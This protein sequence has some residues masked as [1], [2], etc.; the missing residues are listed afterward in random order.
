[1]Q[2][3]PPLAFKRADDHDLAA[4]AQFNREVTGTELSAAYWRWKY[5]DNPRQ[6]S[7]VVLALDADRIVGFMA[8]FALP[9]LVAG[10]ACTAAQL[11]HIELRREYR[12][13][14]SYFA[15]AAALVEQLE[16]P[17]RAAF[18]FG[19]ANDDSRDLSVVMLGFDEI[20]PARKFVRIC[21]PVPHLARRLHLP[22]PAVLGRPLSVLQ[23]MW[24]RRAAGGRMEAVQHFDARHD[25]L[26]KASPKAGVMTIR[27]AAYLNWRFRSGPDAPHYDAFHVRDGDTVIGLGVL[28]TYREGPVRY[29]IVDELLAPSDDDA[30]LDRLV[31]A[32]VAR[33]AAVGVDA[34]VGWCPPGAGLQAALRRGRFVERPAPRTFIVRAQ[35]ASLPAGVLTDELRWYYSIGDTEYWLFPATNNT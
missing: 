30:V 12:S 6:P 21:N 5:L 18:A 13:G 22:L 7:G 27:D 15:L 19:A 32:A 31:A 16:L 20:G 11:G 25:A 26:W 4:I 29:G 9:M 34:I 35:D 8:A 1:M 33:L 3:A 10:R 17:T 14:G 23:A 24:A 2:T 28:H